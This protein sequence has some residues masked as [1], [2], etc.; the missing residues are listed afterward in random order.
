TGYSLGGF[1]ADRYGWR[2]TFLLL[3]A[4]GLVTS[5]LVWLTVRETPR[6]MADGSNVEHKTLGLKSTVR[7]LRSQ[8][9]LR[10]AIFAQ[11]L[12]GVAFMGPIYWLVSFFVRT[13]HTSFA[14]AGTVMGLI[15]LTTGLASGPI[16]GVIMER[17]GLRDV[18]WH[19]RICAWMMLIGAI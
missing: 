7:F 2:T 15:F 17:L 19:G 10:H 13:Y 5:L 8:T 16:G 14:E 12:S 3:G 11:G 6:G 18:S 4:P 1:L 9:A